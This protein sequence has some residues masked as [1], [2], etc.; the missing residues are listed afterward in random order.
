VGAGGALA[1][2]LDGTRDFV[3][4]FNPELQ[5]LAAPIHVDC[6][7]LLERLSSLAENREGAAEVVPQAVLLRLQLRWRSVQLG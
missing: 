4:Q 6:H 7:G 1:L 3:Q 2:K 5:A